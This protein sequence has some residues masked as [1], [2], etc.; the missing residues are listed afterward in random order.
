MKRTALLA[1]GNDNLD[2]GYL[3]LIRAAARLRLVESG[4]LDVDEAI[5][6]LIESIAPDWLIDFL[7]EKR[8]LQILTPGVL[9]R[10]PVKPIVR[11]EDGAKPRRAAA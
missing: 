4:D 2:L 6:G 8:D 11:R 9:Y 5:D 1:S 10:V 3:L 7:V